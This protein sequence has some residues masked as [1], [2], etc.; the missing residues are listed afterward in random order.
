MIW[1]RGLQLKVS[2]IA[3]LHTATVTEGCFFKRMRRVAMTR[4]RVSDLQVDLQLLLLALGLP[5]H[6]LDQPKSVPEG[7]PGSSF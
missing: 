4:G 7:R 5:K 6:D 2:Q 1:Q 3:A